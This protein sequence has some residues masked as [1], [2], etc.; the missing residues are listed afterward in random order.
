MSCQR[1]AP[2]ESRTA[3]S[4][5]R[6]AP[7]ARSRFAMLA[8][9]MSSTIPVMQSSRSNGVR[10]SRCTELCPRRPSVSA[11]R[12]K[13]YTQYARRFS[14][15]AKLGVSTPR[16]E[17]GTNTRGRA[18]TVVPSRSRGATPTMVIGRPLMTIGSFST[19][20]SL[21]SF[22]AQKS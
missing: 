6:F 21:P 20:G 7:R 14:N 9:A 13:R 17:I 10:V 19:C 2:S 3:I 15:L 11:S 18:P 5:D 4:S 22:E 12:A 8:Q 1:V 16:L